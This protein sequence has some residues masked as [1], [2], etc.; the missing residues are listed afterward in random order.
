MRRRP[1]WTA[2]RRD[3]GGAALILALIIV[4]VIAISLGALLSLTDTGIR[5][6]VNLRGQAAAAYEADGALQAAVNNIRQSSVNSSTGSCFGG[7]SN[8]LSLN[9]FSGTDSAVVQCTPDP[10]SVQIQCTSLTHCNRPG[11]AILTLGRIPGEDGINLKPLNSGSVFRVHG[12]VF[13]NSN[14]NVQGT[15]N[16][17]TAVYARG[18]CA[19]TIQSSPAASCNYGN[20]ANA[21]GNDPG[22]TPATAT[23]PVHQPLPA[24]TTKNSVVT[25]L[26]GYYDDAAGLSAMMAGNSA[27]KGSTWWFKPGVY[28]FDF[29]NSD[30]APPP[31]VPAGNDVWT[32]NDGYLVAG[33]PVDSSGKVLSAPSV[34]ASIPGACD[35]PINDPTP[36]RGVQ[37]IF[38][39][40]S[41]F[42][43]KAGQAE[44]CGNYD[45]NTPPVTIYGLTS[46]TATTTNLTGTNTLKTTSVVSA[47]TFTNAT[48]TSLA[49]V[50]GQYATMVNN[51]TGTVTVGGYA[52][53]AAI[54]AGSILQSAQL[55]VV[56]GNT[57]GSTQDGH[58]VQLTPTGGT[59]IPVT[60]PS[61]GDNAVHTDTIDVTN[62]LAQTVYNGAF[63]GAQMVY[64]ASVKHKGTE[65]LDAMQLDLTYVAPA[66]RAESGCITSGPYTGTGSSNCA[67][68]DL[69]G[70]P[71]NKFYVQGTTYAPGAVL[72]VTL[73]NATEQIFRF[74]VIAR[75][76]WV[77]ET[78]SVSY[79]G[80][81]I[82]VPD[83]SPGFVFSV[84]LSVY[85]CLNAATC[86][87][88]PTGTT[89]PPAVS[90]RVA[91]VDGD[92][93]M[94]TPGHRQVSVLS[95][96]GAR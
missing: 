81:V 13:S 64:S 46:G 24:C 83:D 89:T 2:I 7:G 57:A 22:Y 49:T 3:D 56:H 59:S 70:S 37:F 73:N 28:Y 26:P 69:L 76:L 86:S 10:A 45:A 38:G 16:T 25:F 14:I 71:S 74:G 67:L 29:H 79:A 80:P 51:G 75:S 30:S 93:T 94:P 19:G 90:A 9:N 35:S 91:Y 77:K 68:I 61:Y 8:T 18:T 78:G 50:D 6:T 4:T 5:T 53:P 72:D 55:R 39:G 11:S 34:P 43:V 32:V 41:Q 52:P 48:V 33:T 40:D 82:E 66:F 17:N 15:L 63:T 42:A 96:S 12:V 21:L 36:L 85:I 58:T 27:C 47:N 87:P 44:I 60:V 84:F 20:T 23:V 54:P 88:P 92:P 65:E 95:W 62:S 1:T 31:G